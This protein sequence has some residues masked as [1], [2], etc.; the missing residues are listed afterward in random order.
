MQEFIHK[1]ILYIVC[2]SLLS[3]FIKVNAQD[4]EEL[5][6]KSKDSIPFFK[7][8]LTGDPFSLSG[9]YGLSMRSYNTNADMNRQT[10][11]SSTLYANVTARVYD[12]SIP[13]NFILNNLDDFHQPFHKGYL[14]GFLTNQRNRLARF[15]MSPYYKW[16]KVHAGHRYMNFSDY[17]LSNH[18]FL[19]AGVELTPGNFRFSAMAGRLAKSEPVD[20]ALDRPNLPVYRRT[21]WGVKAGYG[22]STDFIDLMLFRAEDDPGSL[23]IPD[24]EGATIQP[25]ENLV[26]GIKGKKTIFDKLSLDFELSRSG[27]TRNLNDPEVGSAALSTDYNNFLFRRK[28]STSYGNAASANLRYSLKKINIGLEYQR[29]DPRFKTFGA[30]FFNDDLENYTFNLSGYGLKNFSFTGT[31]GLQRNNL[32]QSQEATYRRFIGSLNMNYQLETWVFGVNYSNY[33][34]DTRYVLNQDYNSLKVVIV[35]SDASLDISKSIRG[36]GELYHN[37]NFR[38]G[39][40]KVNQ[41][42]ETP[43]GNP[44]T[45]MYYANLGYSLRLPSKWNINLNA[46]YNQNSISG[47]QQTRYGFGGRLGKSW[48]DDQLD[49]SVGARIYSSGDPENE[50]SSTQANENIRLQWKMNSLQTLQLQARSVHNKRSRGGTTD[51]FSE[52]VFSLGFTGRFNYQPFQTNNSEENE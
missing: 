24:T 42:I 44:A 26:I 19:G 36:Q 20:I 33:T 32:D 14:D 15:G 12:I 7:N 51:K 18:N 17:T 2:F 34:S 50:L 38:G 30:Y 6:S 25:A 37:F 28:T 35:T 45:D 8:I 21:G 23:S 43:T 10:P 22:G 49:L 16:I 48:F 47:M 1:K 31:A 27:H 40:Q 5:I 46:D 52:L 9:S 4:V 39:L 41:N 11:L 13:A 3:S 29:I